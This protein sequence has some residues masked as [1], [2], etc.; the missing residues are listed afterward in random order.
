MLVHAHNWFVSKKNGTNSDLSFSD[1]LGSFKSPE[2]SL[3]WYYAT[4]AMPPTMDYTITM[5]L[6]VMLSLKYIWYD[7]DQE[8]E[9]DIHLKENGHAPA[10]MPTEEGMEPVTQSEIKSRVENL[11]RDG[12]FYIMVY[13]R[14]SCMI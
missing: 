13:F 6:A 4:L 9:T 11:K 2:S 3:L 8:V 1:G 14:S 12:M 7:G 5:G 10:E